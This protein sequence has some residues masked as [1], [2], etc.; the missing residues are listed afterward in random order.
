MGTMDYKGDAYY[1]GLVLS[2]DTSAFTFLVDR[3]KDHAFNLAIKVCG[4]YEEAEEIA[5]DA[6]MKAYRSLR[7]FKMKS[8]FSTWLYRIVY[9][10]AIT[11]VRSRKN[12]VL[13][14][15]EFPADFSDFAGSGQCEEEELEEYRRSVVNFAL[16]K[17]VDDDR[18]II[19]LFYYE[20]LSVEEISEITSISK[21]NVKT[22]LFRARQK[23]HEIIVKTEKKNLI[24]NE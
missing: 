22:R 1:T 13:S 9:N 18:A 21:A 23:M 12:R 10:T 20:D 8:S 19:T 3:H 6:F 4:N 14:L 7:G 2:G 16:Q 5:Q 15:E 24:F 11:V 17:L